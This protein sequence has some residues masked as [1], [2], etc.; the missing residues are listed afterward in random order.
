MNG[1]IFKRCL[2]MVLLHTHLKIYTCSVIFSQIMYISYLK[3]TK[4]WLYISSRGSQ[5]NVLRQ[6]LFELDRVTSDW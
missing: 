1:L 4:Y 5:V 6:S 2:L 3:T